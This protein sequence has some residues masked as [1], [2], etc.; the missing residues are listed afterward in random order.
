MPFGLAN[1][2]AVF[3]RFM[4]SMLGN[5]RHDTALAYLDDILVPSVT[6]EE[7]FKKLEDILKLLR[8]NGL[9]L[10]LSKCYFFDSSLDYLG[11]E[12]SAEGIRPDKNKILAVEKFPIPLNIHEVRQFLGLAGY[13]RKFIK[14]FGEI[15]RPLTNLLRKGN[16]FK[17]TDN[18]LNAFET[19][20]EKLIHRPILALYN[21]KFKTEL[22]TDAS[23]LGVGGILMQWQSV[24]DVLKP[25]AYFSR[26]T[27]PE[28]R[29]LH[30]YELET[31]AIVCALKKFRVYLLGLEFK[32]VTDCNAL[33][34][35]LTKRDLIPRIARWWLLISEFNFS[36]EYRP[37]ARMG[38][39]D[40]LS[41]NTKL[42][43][44]VID[45]STL[46]V[47]NIE[48]SNWLLT[49]QMTDPDISR[50]FK[51]LKPESNEETKD[52]KKNYVIKNNRVYRRVGKALCL[53]VPRGARWQIS[54]EA[55][56]FCSSRQSLGTLVIRDRWFE[57]LFNLTI[58]LHVRGLPLHKDIATN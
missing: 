23:S 51:I 15:A 5:K 46:T 6:L 32:I 57:P 52:I 11:Y 27:T 33:R 56:N 30:S 44:E 20:K 34:T 13:F 9:T 40:A 28:E 47:Y 12:I 14:G 17:W 43:P 58:T 48:T 7:G 10:K 31:L 45:D 8:L 18:E 16:T 50:I 41:R 22:H 2:P 37:G 55:K 49:L 3:Q 35:T 54:N 39:V 25:V 36:I 26:Q 29:H 42:S 1:A 19:L 4:N 53:V 21:P 38:H 24:S